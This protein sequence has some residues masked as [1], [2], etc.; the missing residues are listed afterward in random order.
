M[1]FFVDIEHTSCLNAP[2]LHN[3]TCVNLPERTFKCIC[4]PS[5]IGIYCEIGKKMI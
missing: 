5:F 2:C 4:S 3:S 1:T